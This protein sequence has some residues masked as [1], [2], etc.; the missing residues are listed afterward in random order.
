ME[1]RARQEAAYDYDKV[2]IRQQGMDL[3]RPTEVKIA[4]VTDNLAPRYPDL[5]GN[6]KGKFER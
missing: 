6:L 2:S 1:I 5:K 4:A 3:R